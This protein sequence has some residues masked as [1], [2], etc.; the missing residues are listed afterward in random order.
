MPGLLDL[1]GGEEWRRVDGGDGA[2]GIESYGNVVGGDGV[3]KFGQ[4]QYVISIVGEKGAEE[5]AAE[6][7]DWSANRGERIDRFA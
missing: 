3:G 7:F 4:G 6:G 1:R 5:F 2:A